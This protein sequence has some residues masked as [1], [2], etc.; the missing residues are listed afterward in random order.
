MLENKIKWKSKNYKISNS[1]FES[2]YFLI[3]FLLELI[4]E[5]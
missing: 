2:T 1:I 4:G 5:H 3:I